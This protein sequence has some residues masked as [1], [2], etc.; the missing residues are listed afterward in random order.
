LRR[1]TRRL[2]LR[3]IRKKQR[4]TDIAQRTRFLASTD[5]KKGYWRRKRGKGGRNTPTDKRN[6]TSQ[7]EN[8][9]GKRGGEK[10]HF[11]AHCLEEGRAVRIGLNSGTLPL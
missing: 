10:A 5:T 4:V 3:R 1:R 7:L 6:R 8:F 2:T 11:S 9:H